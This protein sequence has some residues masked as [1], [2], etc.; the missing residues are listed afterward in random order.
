LSGGNRAA[1]V[2]GSIHA[3]CIN[4]AFAKFG[5]HRGA[6]PPVTREHEYEWHPLFRV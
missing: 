1:G 4:A 6:Q 2:V 5:A 3:Q